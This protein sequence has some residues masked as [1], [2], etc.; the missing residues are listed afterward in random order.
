MIRNITNNKLIIE[1]ILLLYGKIRQK[2]L[3]RKK[4]MMCIYNYVSMKGGGII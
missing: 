2:I 3:E 1:T 4:E